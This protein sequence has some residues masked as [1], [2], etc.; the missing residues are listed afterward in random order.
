MTAIKE[1]QKL[2]ELHFKWWDVMYMSEKAWVILDEILM[3]NPP[4]FIRI[5][6]ETIQRSEIARLKPKEVADTLEAYILS[7][8]KEMRD[9]I[10]SYAKSKNITRKSVEHVSNFIQANA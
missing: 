8:P 3:N 6:W 9:K 7:Q 2:Y 10:E 5:A 4:L 1:H